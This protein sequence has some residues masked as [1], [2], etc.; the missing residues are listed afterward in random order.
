MLDI[1]IVVN[2]TGWSLDITG[3]T[4]NVGLPVSFSGTHADSS[5][6]NTV[7]TGY[8]Y[9]FNQSE[10]PNLAISI[11]RVV[12]ESLAEAEAVIVPSVTEGF[13]PLEVVFDGSGSGSIGTI[14]N[15][16]WVFGDGTTASGVLATNTF[17][18]PNT[19]TNWL[20]IMDDQGYAATNSV[21]ITVNPA[22]QANIVT[23]QSGL[24]PPLEV[25]FD[26][27]T[28]SSV[29][30]TVTNYSWAFGDGNTAAGVMATNTYTEV[31]VYTAW[32]TVMDDQGNI[33]SNSV[34]ITA[35]EITYGVIID[36]DFDDGDISVNTL[37]IG[38]GFASGAQSGGSVTEINNAAVIDSPLNG[39]RRARISSIDTADTTAADGASYLFEGLSFAFSSND[40]GDGSTHRTYIGI[41]DNAGAGDEGDN[42]EEGFY[43]EFGY[44]S[45][46]GNAAGT[47]TFLY[48]SA[49][50]VKTTLATW[51]FDNLLVTDAA[52]SSNVVLDVEITVTA[53]D[54]SIDI[55]GD[56]YNGGSAISFSGTH[57]AYSITNTVDSGHAF[58]HNQ[59]ES[60]NLAMSIGRVVVEQV[61]GGALVVPNITSIT[62]DGTTVS[63]S[64]ESEPG[65]SYNVLSRA[66]LGLGGW[67]T[68][69]TAVPSEGSTTSTTVAPSGEPAEFFRI[70]AY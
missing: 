44:G 51:T 15:Y 54:W 32:L 10:S 70:E 34:E 43:L 14:T 37:G 60:P 12:V 13:N 61:Q 20:T 36:D 8:A 41:R 65:F 2:D 47:S 30:G 19:Y 27:S 55:L 5:I 62:H 42:P 16:A 11:G 67:S 29:Y 7:N 59:S 39:G 50:N 58:A 45:M 18:L 4:Y 31:G 1:S 40:S 53:T 28:S 57:A 9:A 69:V 21:V 68:N 35:A 24:Y 66:V 33:S 26:A 3:D 63:L 38:S 6:A 46:S 25:V 17:L 49:S 52:V 64:W 48:N 56:T 22:L 23:S